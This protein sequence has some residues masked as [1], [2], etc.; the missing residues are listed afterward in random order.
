MG[1]TIRILRFGSSPSETTLGVLSVQPDAKLKTRTT[2][3]PQFLGLTRS[4]QLWEKSN[5]GMG[6][7][8]GVLD[9]E[10]DSKH[11]SFSGD[12]M[13]PPPPSWTGRCD[14]ER[15]NCN[16][17]L[18]GNR[19]FSDSGYNSAFPF[20]HGTHVASTA[21]GSPVVGANFKGQAAGSASGTAPRAHLA[22]YSAFWESDWTMAIDQ[23][24]NDGV[25]VLSISI[26]VHRARPFYSSVMDIA[27]LSAIQNGI[28][29]SVAAGNDGPGSGSILDSAPWALSVGASTTDRVTRIE[30]RLRNGDV[31]DAETADAENDFFPLGASLS[32]VSPGGNCEGSSIGEVD[33]PGK[34]V[35]CRYGEGMS[36]RGITCNVAKYGGKAVILANEMAPGSTVVYFPH[37]DIPT[38]FVNFVEGQKLMG[39]ARAE[40]NATLSFESVGTIT[41]VRRHPAVAYFSGRGPSPV[42]NMVLKP[43][44]LGPG[45]NI[46]A[47]YVRFTGSTNQFRYDSG[48]SMACPHLSGIAAMLISLHPTWSP[49]MI[50][51]AIMTTSDW[52][53]NAGMPIA[54]HTG[55]PASLFA[56]GS[57]QVNA[58]RAADP[59]LVYDIQR[60]DYVKYVC[61]LEYTPD[62]VNQVIKEEVD[63]E[64]VGRISGED[65]NY[66]SFYVKASSNPRM[67]TRTVMNV[68]LPRE[69]YT[70]SLQQPP[71]AM[72][73]VFPRTLD[74]IDVGERLSYTVTVTSTN[75]RRSRGQ[76]EEGQLTWV[77]AHH[78]VRSPIAITFA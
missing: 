62:Q 52:Q 34:V 57:G 75:P 37:C 51:S 70:L 40:P 22:F 8:I 33:V 32:A 46:L 54:D 67:I 65:L 58:T 11:D 50:K 35:L 73:D 4:G 53:D 16:N 27:T 6:K 61:G 7:V 36:V 28:F 66:P 1:H 20:D 44:I 14:V 55:E 5:S 9:V 21:A 30:I 26:G 47:A 29:V 25:D 45:V 76:V 68:G 23:A 63:C 74:F 64:V 39:Y 38:V 17:K 2:H 60:D 19:K 59:G 72:I 77:S 42:N 41:G 15:T 78:R 69:R 18:I 43:D 31:I 13:P 10:I 56:A 49:A 71:D 3:S 24:I 48:T 12:D